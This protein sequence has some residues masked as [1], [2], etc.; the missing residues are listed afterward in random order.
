MAAVSVPLSVVR[1]L[2]YN[3]S[4]VWH[5]EDGIPRDAEIV[6]TIYRPEK[7]EVVIIF[8]HPSFSSLVHSPG[9]T[10]RIVPKITMLGPDGIKS[11]PGNSN[12]E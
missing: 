2:C 9:E 1:F 6:D 7:R 10:R 3:G 4:R 8:S 12:T 11:T 5:I